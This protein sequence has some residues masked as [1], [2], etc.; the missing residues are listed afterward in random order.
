MGH[1]M[2]ANLRNITHRVRR[3]I[4]V[5]AT[6]LVASLATAVG[7]AQEYQVTRPPAEFRVG[8][9]R[10]FDGSRPLIRAHHGPLRSL[11][12]PGWAGGQLSIHSFGL[13]PFYQKYI[14]AG[15]YPIVSSRRVND[16]ALKEAAYLVNLMLTKR[17][18]V[19]R[20]MIDSGSRMVIMAHD[21]FTTD[22][23]EYEYL[24]PNDYWDARARGLGG[25]Q[26]DPIC[27]AAEE[28][29][30]A[31][32][33]DP[34]STECILIHEFAHNIHLRGLVRVDPTFDRRLKEA[35][36]AAIAGGLWRRKYAATNHHEYWAEGVQSWFDNNRP[37]DHDHN[38]VDTRKELIEYD[39]RLAKLCHEV[40][41]DTKLVYTKPTT[42]LTGHLA[43]YDPAK[44]PRFRWPE[45][46]KDIHLDVQLKWLS[47]PG[48]KTFRSKP[49][50]R[51]TWVLFD[52]RSK[53]RVKLHWVNYRGRAVPR[54]E[55]GRGRMA[56]H[57]TTSGSAW[58]ITDMA[59][60]PLGRF[61]AEREVSQAKI[62]GKK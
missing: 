60:K 10:V 17:P 44:A 32:P 37:P 13:G 36:D 34:Y 39:P 28:N 62:P 55:I 30:L 16:Y 52:N 48:E 40:F 57:R 53:R 11:A 19:R 3:G 49:R 8:F 1:V 61:V 58:L 5:V 4:I 20:A 21:E 14:S 56:P 15:G 7:T 27:S 9:S 23:P 12:H 46:L 6:G 31:F 45:R 2:N 33:G 22:V 25:S 42:R 47:G 35:Y 29:V 38:H 59:G 26:D 50:G 54:G 24:Q 43:G 18:D 51:R 41:G